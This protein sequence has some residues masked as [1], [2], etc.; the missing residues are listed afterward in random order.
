MTF[1][2][3]GSPIVDVSFEVC[4]LLLCERGGLR[5][6]RGRKRD[7]QTERESYIHV[8][9][10]YYTYHLCVSFLLWMQVPFICDYQTSSYTIVIST[11][12]QPDVTRAS[13]YTGLNRMIVEIFDSELQANKNYTTTISIED[14]HY[15]GKVLTATIFSKSMHVC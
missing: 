9:T 11:P 5:G 12:G 15:E 3:D 13:T 2:R 10:H 6:E 4:R 1:L 8:R 7:R 14:E